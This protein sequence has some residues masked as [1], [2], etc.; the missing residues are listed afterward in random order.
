MILFMFKQV[1]FLGAGWGVL[2]CCHGGIGE[3]P[4][5]SELFFS[6]RTKENYLSLDDPVRHLRQIF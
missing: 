3:P 6:I 5:P 1:Y 4:V 2:T